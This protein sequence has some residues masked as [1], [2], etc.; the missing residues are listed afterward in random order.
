TEI[1]TLSLTTLFRSWIQQH[2]HSLDAAA[3]RMQPAPPSDNK[4]AQ[5]LGPVGPIAVLLAKGKVLLTALFKLKFLLSFAA[6][7]GLYWAAFGMAFG[8]GFAVLIL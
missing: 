6:F 1:Y 8:I 7:I 3:D 2:A 4:W 5:K